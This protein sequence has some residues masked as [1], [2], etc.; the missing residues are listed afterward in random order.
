MK[1]K[2]PGKSQFVVTYELIFWQKHFYFSASKVSYHGDNVRV[3]S[4][5]LGE[6]VLM[7]FSPING[8][9]AR[10]DEYAGWLLGPGENVPLRKHTNRHQTRGHPSPENWQSEIN[11]IIFDKAPILIH[12]DG[13]MDGWMDIIS[14]SNNWN[15]KEIC[16]PSIS[17]N[18]KV[19]HRK[20]KE[21]LS[22]HFRN[23]CESFH[24][25]R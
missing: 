1:S 5:Q 16:F 20:F 21:N 13:W 7:K 19:I 24:Y 25:F 11:S 18:C 8:P 2:F 12:M 14:N 17:T 6:W 4:L 15:N 22:N 9:C 23:P 3:A 10:A